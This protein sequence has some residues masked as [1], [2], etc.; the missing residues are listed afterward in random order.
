MNLLQKVDTVIG[1]RCIVV[2]EDESWEVGGCE[3]LCELLLVMVM[4]NV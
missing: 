4:V 1:E 3:K 2:D